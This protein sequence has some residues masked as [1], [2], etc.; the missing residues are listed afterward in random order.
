M[1]Q[2]VL[3]AI[4]LFVLCRLM[5]RQ[6]E[7]KIDTWEIFVIA[8]IPGLVVWGAAVLAN[9][10]DLPKWLIL[11]SNLA[12]LVV[13]YLLLTEQYQYGNRQAAIYASYVAVSFI[14]VQFL[15]VAIT[16]IFHLEIRT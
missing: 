14:V 8:V 6:K 9:L 5:E 7:K 10:A 16:N 11:A 15:L 3:I 4:A 2:G 13:P 12:Y 1:L